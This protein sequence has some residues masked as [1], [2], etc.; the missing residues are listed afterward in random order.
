ME[1]VTKYPVGFCQYGI[2]VLR[3]H[4]GNPIWDHKMS[5]FMNLHTP[6]CPTQYYIKWHG[7]VWFAE[8]YQID[9]EIKKWR[10]PRKSKML[11]KKY[12]GYTRKGNNPKVRKSHYSI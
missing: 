9:E 5:R 4:P 1:Q 2:T 11:D 7:Q 10:R 3:I 12:E 6:H 8:E